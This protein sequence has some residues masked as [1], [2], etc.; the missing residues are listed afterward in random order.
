MINAPRWVLFS[1]QLFSGRFYKIFIKN[2][3]KV[4]A[5][6]EVNKT[7]YGVDG[8]MLDP[9]IFLTSLKRGLS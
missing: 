6:D 2:L 8:V 4:T 1:L 5:Y 7:Q 3:A 9:N